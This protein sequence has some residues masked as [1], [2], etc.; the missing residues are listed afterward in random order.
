MENTRR[1]LLFASILSVLVLVSVGS[2][3]CGDDGVTPEDDGGNNGNGGPQLDT[4]PPAAVTDLRQ[5]APTY[6]TVALAWTAPGDDGD[7][8]T[9]DRYEIRHSMSPITADNWDDAT[10]LDP[11]MLPAPKPAG[12]IET[13][14]VTKLH[15]GTEYYF[16]LKSIDEKNNVSEL[17][18]NA[19]GST[20]TETFPPADVTDLKATGIS[21]G[22][23]E[24]TWTAPGDDF[25]A[26]TATRYDIR[27][28]PRL[29]S[30]PPRP[31]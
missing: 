25:M 2:T 3:G 16:A 8:G 27:Y 18:N 22:S 12:Q 5:R 26:G 21:T 30:P 10:P 15:S 28:S 4:I 19:S 6:Q 9:A 11:G 29:R 13:V 7:K 24:L 31:D 14:V 23:F 1:V 20:L 17:S